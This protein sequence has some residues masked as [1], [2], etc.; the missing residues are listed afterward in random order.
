MSM[1]GDRKLLFDKAVRAHQAG[2]LSEAVS[3]YETL[4]Q[5]Q[6]D[7][8]VTGLLGAAL[9]QDGRLEEGLARLH[10]ASTAAPQNLTILNNYGNALCLARRCEE[11]ERIYVQALEH[12]PSNDQM[13]SRLFALCN[14]NGRFERVIEAAERRLSRDPD[15]IDAHVTLADAYFMTG[16]LERG[17]AEFEWRWKAEG[18]VRDRERYFNRPLWDDR[19]PLGQRTLLIH[20]EMGVGDTLHMIRFV[21]WLTRRHPE[22]R[23]VLFVDPNLRDL[24]ADSFAAYPA[25]RVQQTEANRIDLSYDLHLPLMSLARVYGATLDD[26]ENRVPYISVP[27]ARRYGEGRDLVIGLAWHSKAVEDGARRSVPLE[28]FLPFCAIPRVKLVDLQYGDTEKERQAFAGQGGHII[29]DETVD[30]LASIQDFA[31]QIMGCDLVLSIDNSTAHV[32]GALGKRAWV[33]LHTTANWRWLKERS[34]SPWYPSLRL[35]RQ[36]RTGTWPPVLE[37]VTADLRALAAT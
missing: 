12:D 26:L 11:A 28:A 34:D 17:W 35:Y 31:G 13:F 19:R 5:A 3:I 29:H 37:R 32:A 36:D 8:T 27:P 9:A 30:Q 18:Y 24:L 20:A 16:D 1:T 23:F 25:V 2:E 4:L 21:P 33:L 7:A 14:E 10:E 22:A 6:A 15:D